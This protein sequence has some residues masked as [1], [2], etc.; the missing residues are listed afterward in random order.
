MRITSIFNYDLN[1]GE[2]VEVHSR[3][4]SIKDFGVDGKWSSLIE[5]DGID[6]YP[7]IYNISENELM[8]IKNIAL[9]KLSNSL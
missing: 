1:N 4:Y 9:E 8:N 6:I 3:G 5:L 2:T 7:E